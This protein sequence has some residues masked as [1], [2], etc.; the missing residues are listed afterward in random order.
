M[1]YGPLPAPIETF[2]SWQ[3]RVY[4]THA[5]AEKAEKEARPG[6]FVTV[7][8]A[9]GCEGMPLAERLAERLNA[10]SA[11]PTPWVVMGKEIIGA[12]AGRK[13]EAARF[14][15]ALSH[16]RRG[17]I[18]QTVE[19]LLGNHPTEYQAYETLVEALLLL[20]R[21]GRVVL[22]GQGAG[23][24]CAGA[25]RGYHA[26]LVAPLAW[27]AAKLAGARGI[28]TPAAETL[29][30]REEQARESFVREFTGLDVTD[31]ERYD[32]VLNNG[33]NTV[34]EMADLIAAAL[35]AKGYV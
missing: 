31:P 21:A 4:S 12:V 8:R 2:L 14:V 28:G 25:E 27:R 32:L 24:V 29:A 17:F 11:R 9:F 30:A 34:R 5:P 15:E 22:V 26:R 35:R 10:I 19:V 33:R 13:G 20:A 18:Q 1:V 6:P 23:I 16:G 7:S 3:A